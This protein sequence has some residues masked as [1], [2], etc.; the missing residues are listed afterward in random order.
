MR[1]KIENGTEICNL[2]VQDNVKKR[3]IHLQ[4]VVVV[5]EAQLSEFVHEEIYS[6]T[7]CA[8]HFRQSFLTHLRTP[9]S[10]LLGASQSHILCCRRLR[11]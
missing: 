10:F 8:D 5:D 7:S 9:G 6:S 11:D 2:L 1:S 3:A 4:P